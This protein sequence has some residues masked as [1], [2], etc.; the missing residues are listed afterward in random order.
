MLFAG[1]HVVSGKA[2]ALVILT[3]EATEF[4]TLSTHL[5]SAPP[6]T[7]FELG[8]RNFGYLLLEVAAA[9]SLLVFAIN[10]TYERPILD[11]LLFTLALVVG[12]TPQLLP[13]I[14]TATLAQG[15]HR[16]ALKQVVVRRLNSIADLG[17]ISVLCTDKTGT[18]T[19]GTVTWEASTLY[20]GTP[21]GKTALFAYLNALYETGFSNVIDDTIRACPQG[22]ADTYSK[23]DEIPYDFTRRLLSIAVD[24]PQSRILMTK[25]AFKEVLAHCSSVEI[26]DGRAVPLEPVAESI[27][28]RFEHLS[29]QG[30]RC[31]GVAYREIPRDVEISK[32]T[33]RDLTFLGFIQF[34]DPIKS[35]AI[36]SIQA[37]ENLGITCKVVTGDNRFVAT[38][39]GKDLGVLSVDRILTGEELETLSDE[40]L[41]VRVQE[42]DIFA[43]VNPHQK[44]RIILALKKLNLGVGYLGD[45]INDAAALRAGDVGISVDTATDVTKEA[46]DIVLLNKDL[47]LLLTAVTEGRMAFANTLKYILVTTSA[48]FGNMFSVAGASLFADFLPMLPPQILLLNVLSDLPAMAIA[49]DRV[50]PE[51]TEKPLRWS[52][53]SI[54]SFMLVYGLISSVFDYLTFGV[55]LILNLGAPAFRTGWFIESV[56]SEV[57]V[58]L[59]IRTR[60][61]IWKSKIGIILAIMSSVTCILT[62]VIPY[63]PIAGLMGF[64]ALMPSTLGIVTFILFAYIG[65]SELAK[66]ILSRRAGSPNRAIRLAA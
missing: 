11:V 35:T 59:V 56:I 39:L 42:V 31:L 27:A 18:L 17:G 7:E 41:R 8:V 15:A 13:A 21:S 14:A 5:R 50:D 26:G 30:Y 37:L 58:L 3:G 40:A 54:A 24:T 23:V 63:S 64:S 55:L 20:D 19:E 44:E 57:L 66:R 51:M 25:G 16:M 28:R 38:K 61:S 45:G 48:N 49:T 52:S 1:C 12:M 4:G 36:S 62:L 53:R 34:A 46:A 22:G 9:L 32:D 29:T 10:L 47:H 6:P 65:S 2:T 43:E 60:R 33:E